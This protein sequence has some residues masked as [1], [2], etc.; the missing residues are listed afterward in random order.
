MI[1]WKNIFIE[2]DHR[3]TLKREFNKILIKSFIFDER[4]FL[5]NIFCLILFQ[6]Y[7]IFN[8]RIKIQFFWWLPIF[9]RTQTLEA[10]FTILKYFFSNMILKEKLTKPQ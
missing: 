8:N 10:F 2:S 4:T 6:S 9:N 1:F 7:F 5:L 3:I